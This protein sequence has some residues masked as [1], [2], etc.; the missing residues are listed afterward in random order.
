MRLGQPCASDIELTGSAHDVA[1][2]GS[3]WQGPPGHSHSIPAPLSDSHQLRTELTVYTQLDIVLVLSPILQQI[4]HHKL[5][6][7]V[8]CISHPLA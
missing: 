1:V 6:C 7:N 8:V 5:N 4:P 2:S 3:A